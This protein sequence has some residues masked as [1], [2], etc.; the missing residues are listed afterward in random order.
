M[1]RAK[2][3]RLGLILF[4]KPHLRFIDILNMD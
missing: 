3:G 2:G 4:L 1:I